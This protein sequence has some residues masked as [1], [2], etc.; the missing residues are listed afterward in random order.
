M[1]S[2]EFE[3]RITEIFLDLQ[4]DREKKGAA[5]NLIDKTRTL[6]PDTKIAN[7]LGD[8][9]RNEI[10]YNPDFFERILRKKNENLIRFILLHEEAHISSGK[11]RVPVQFFL[12]FG[13]VLTCAIWLLISRMS[14][15]IVFPDTRYEISTVVSVI[16]F[17]CACYFIG[18]PAIWRYNWDVMFDDEFSADT[19]ATECLMNVLNDP[20][21]VTTVTPYFI[22]EIQV[23][24]QEKIDRKIMLMKHLGVYPDYHPSNAERL[25]RIQRLFF[26]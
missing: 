10:R 1:D 2:M 5:V 12:F 17:C 6:I 11:S 24:E 8:K 25:D 15:Q 21:P 9:A 20:D 18:A 3:K 19:Y 22:E 4:K 26:R 14:L 13:A 7:A 23:Q 16:L